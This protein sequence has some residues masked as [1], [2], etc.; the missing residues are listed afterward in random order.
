MV[1]N[2]EL[3]CLVYKTINSLFFTVSLFSKLFSLLF[4]FK[5]FFIAQTHFKPE[6]E[7]IFEV[8]YEYQLKTI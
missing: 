6:L 2:T 4:P 5:I 7:I 1:Y 3:N 8:G